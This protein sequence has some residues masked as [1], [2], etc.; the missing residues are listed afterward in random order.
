MNWKLHKVPC[1]FIYLIPNAA[2]EGNLLL[3]SITLEG[4]EYFNTIDGHDDKVL[5][6]IEEKRFLPKRKPKNGDRIAILD[7]KDW[8]TVETT[9]WFKNYFRLEVFRVK[10]SRLVKEA[11]YWVEA[12]EDFEALKFRLFQAYTIEE[13]NKKENIEKPVILVK[14]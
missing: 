11:E 5:C 3:Y 4:K 7:H 14:P 13:L 8:E 9:N 12:D 6:I 2:L 1:N 10:K